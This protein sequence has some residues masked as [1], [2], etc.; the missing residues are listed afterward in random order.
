VT[1]TIYKKPLAASGRKNEKNSI[2]SYGGN[3]PSIERIA[4]VQGGLE[5]CAPLARA[6]CCKHFNST[7]DRRSPRY[8]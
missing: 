7:A 8:L 2:G 5:N 1:E 6:T 4:A 3:L